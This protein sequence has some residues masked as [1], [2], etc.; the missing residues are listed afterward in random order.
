M[1]HVLRLHAA[2][3][4]VRA[5][6]VSAFALTVACSSAPDDGTDTNGTDPNDPHAYGIATCARMARCSPDVLK[7]VY[8]DID[9]C[10]EIEGANS[11]NDL[12]SA[13]PSIDGSQISACVDHLG[14]GACGTS[15]P[16]CDFRGALPVDAPCGTSEQ[17]ASGYCKHGTDPATHDRNACGKCAATVGPGGDCTHAV[18]YSDNETCVNNKCTPLPNRGEACDPNSRPCSSS[19]LT[20]VN[21]TCVD[22]LPPGSACKTGTGSISCQSGYSCIG[23]KCI[24]PTVTYANTGEACNVDTTSPTRIKC[25]AGACIKN[26]CVAYADVGQPCGTVG[27][28]GSL[29]CRNGQCAVDDPAACK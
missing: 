21:K 23:S 24:Q 8:T 29:V 27:C 5:F 19:T 22:R 10:N 26:T 20:C 3:A 17:C 18:C 1:S 4:K 16:E 12:S 28:M 2:S 25:L 6:V 13:G 11:A 14:S 9:K 7:Q 15:T